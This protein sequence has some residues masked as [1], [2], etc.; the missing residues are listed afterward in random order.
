MEQ[1]E[2]R[3]DAIVE[4]MIR[5]AGNKGYLAT[6]VAD[7][8]VEAGVSRTTFYKHFADKRECFLVAYDLAIE[9]I[10]AVT[11]SACEPGR[12]WRDRARSGLAAVVELLAADPAL[13]RVAVVEASAAGPEARRRHWATIDRFARLLEPGSPQQR[14]ELPPGTALMATGAVLGL[15]LD[16]LRE[17]RAANLPQILPE[18]EFALLVP[19]LGPKIAAEVF[20]E[21]AST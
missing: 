19:Y 10:L 20:T 18:L 16:E 4:A 11:E 9:R 1:G 21:T 8:L 12:R 3:R 7:V 14:Y 15:I 2:T 17:D 5:V 13:A 6:S